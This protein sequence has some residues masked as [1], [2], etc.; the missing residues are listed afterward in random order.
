MHLIHVNSV[1]ATL[2]L[3]TTLGF[4][5]TSSG[6]LLGIVVDDSGKPI[7]GAT[8]SYKSAQTKAAGVKG[9][10]AITGPLIGSA[11]KTLADGS[12]S[13]SGLP[14]AIYHLCAYGTR[15]NH[16]DSCQWGTGTTGVELTAGDTVQLRFVVSEGTLVTFQVEDPKHQIRDF[17]SLPL[18]NGRIP[19]ARANFAVGIWAGT[20]YVRA[21]LVSTNGNMRRYQTAVPK[22]ATVQVV[23]DTSLRVAD[24][25]GFVI[26]GTG[27]AVMAGGNREVIV[28][29]AIP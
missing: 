23:V 25:N 26:H 10:P 21:G 29:L 1:C 20:R 9:Q 13:I 3:T 16:L 8:V 28:N 15:D 2:I 5:A 7:G 14:P 27:P 17:E 11:V 18:I 19:W 24:A 22:T 12:F 6:A 4:G